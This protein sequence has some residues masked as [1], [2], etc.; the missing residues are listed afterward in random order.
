MA[1]TKSAT[2][3]L[4]RK[5]FLPPEDIKRILAGDPN[6]GDLEVETDFIQRLQ[7]FSIKNPD[8][9]LDGVQGFTLKSFM[10]HPALPDARKQKLLA[11][12]RAGRFNKKREAA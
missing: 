5:K 11:D 4:K 3:P 8:L 7:H 9:T 6:H 12:A 1:R 2:T 10:E